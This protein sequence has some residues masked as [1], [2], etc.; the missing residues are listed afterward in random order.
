MESTFLIGIVNNITLLLVLGFLYSVSIRRWD[1]KTVKGQLIAG[2][3]FGLVAMIGMVVPVQY[4]PGLIFDGRTILLGTVGLFGGGLAAAVAVV[5]TGLLRIWQGGVGQ[6]AGL[7]TILSASLLGLLFRR[8]QI[9]FAWNRNN[10]LLYVSGL[11]IHL[12][13]LACMLILPESIRW[14]VLA[15]IS[16]PVLLVYPVATMLYGRLIV[17]LEEHND[18]ADKLRDSQQLYQALAESSTAGIGLRDE[19]GRFA[20]VNKMLAMMLEAAEP[21]Q[22]IGLNYIDFV[23]PEDREESLRRIRSNQI[24]EVASRREHRL[25]SLSGKI[26]WVESTGVPFLM[27]DC[28]YI[29]GV[30]H[31][32]T[33]RKRMEQALREN[34]ERYRAMMQQSNESILLVDMETKRILEVNRHCVEMFGY[35]EPELLNMTTYDVV[36]DT[37]ENID[38][39]SDTIACGTGPNEQLIQI[40][41]KNGK[42][43]EVERAATI[44]QYGG[45]HVFMFANRDI[46]AERKLQGLILRDVAM[47]AGVQKDLLPRG[48]DDLLVSVETVYEPH[49]LVSGDFFDFAWSEDH[50]RL[51]GFILDVSGHG[52]SS[53]LQCIAVSTYFRDIL[54][55]PMSLDARLK[56]VNRHVLRYFTHETF[57]AALGFEFD[58]SRRSLTFATAGI[59]GFLAESHALPRL[60]K[61]PGSLLGILDNPEYTEWTVPIKAGDAF[62]FM[63]DG[64]FDVVSRDADLPT[65]DYKQAVRTLRDIAAS[66]QRR[67]DCSA[68][69]ILIND[70]P[71]FPVR[72]EF[73]RYGEY[74]RIRSRI[75]D[76]LQNVS[77][78]HAPRIEIAIGEALANAL[79]E[80]MDVRVKISLCGRRLMVRISD[81]GNGFDG[82]QRVATFRAVDMESEFLDRL[83]SEGGRGI[84]IMLAWMDQVIYSRKGNEVLLV[85]NLEPVRTE[86]NRDGDPSAKQRC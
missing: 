78:Q 86:V 30:F 27:K 61:R 73:H 35:S 39:R 6:W 63:S 81:G 7:A 22:L 48:F 70:Q 9:R 28:R 82:K 75:R 85:K 31:D 67:D 74:N 44:I 24:G 66:P 43:L 56:W 41:C 10:L 77:L 64:L 53:A 38:R 21:S 83:Y 45:K 57:A 15:D 19:A 25:I 59:Y 33:D 17:G 79:R 58:F 8:M 13:M 54:N 26:V 40:R 51:S 62:Y 11:V 3:L 52:V 60:V 65:A 2:L 68:V 5:M 1:I 84:L 46:S 14:K 4:S 80:S 47:A 32:C 16:L 29:M 69:C 20:Y 71:R 23:H 12:A 36:A 76:L 42:L 34:E 55:S 18:A 50:K 49:H 72:L 37:R